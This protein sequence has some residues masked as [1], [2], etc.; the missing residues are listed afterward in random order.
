MARNPV[1]IYPAHGRCTSAS[2]GRKCRHTI[3]DNAYP[4]D[5]AF[6]GLHTLNDE[7]LGPG[8]ANSSSLRSGE[9]VLI[10]PIEGALQLELN[11]NKSSVDVGTV[12]VLTTDSVCA[13]T[14][15]NP[16][17]SS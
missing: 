9:I 6:A 17:Q 13:I 2:P 10:V 8:H 14:V 3:G 16:Y 5:R 11:N 4:H 12:A 1:V 7:M 15:R